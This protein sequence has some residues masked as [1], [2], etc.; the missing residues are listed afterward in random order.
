MHKSMKVWPHDQRALN[1]SEKDRV[2]QNTQI[3]YLAHYLA[4]G[5][6]VQRLIVEIPKVL[7]RKS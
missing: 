6:P 4:A 1:L 5:R 2:E 3:I 7:L